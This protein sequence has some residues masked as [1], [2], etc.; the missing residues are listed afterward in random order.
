MTE[1]TRTWELRPR[2]LVV[3]EQRLAIGTGPH[4]PSAIVEAVLAAAIGEAR[5]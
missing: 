5:A 3:V 1:D 4:E 2:C